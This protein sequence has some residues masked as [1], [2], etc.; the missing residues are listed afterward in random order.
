MKKTADSQ[1][2]RP[3]KVIISDYVY[4]VVYE[5]DIYLENPSEDGKLFE[6]FGY[7]QEGSAIKISNKYSPI[8]QK[9]TVLH[10]SIHAI[11]RNIG[12]E[13]EERQV[14]SFAHALVFF[15]K[16]NKEFIKWILEDE[17]NIKVIEDA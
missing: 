8:V 1:L 14:E 13:L 5:D 2:K 17:E 16:Q 15:M 11:D 4:P 12:L 9:H 10:E 7:F 3:S 6:A